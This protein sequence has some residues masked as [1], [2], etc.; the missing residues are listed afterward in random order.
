LLASATT[1]LLLRQR[2]LKAIVEDYGA[3]KAAAE[4]AVDVAV[5]RQLICALYHIRAWVYRRKGRCL[6]DSL[7]LLRFLSGYGCYPSWVFGVQVRPFRAHTWVQ[8]EQWILNGTPAYV[9][10]YMPILVI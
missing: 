3:R 10:A 7:T 5:I 1:A 8:H 2:P 6:F 9:R 4:D